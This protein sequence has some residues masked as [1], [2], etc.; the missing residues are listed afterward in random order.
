MQNIF[1]FVALKEWEIKYRRLH[2]PGIVTQDIMKTSSGK[3]YLKN[4]IMHTIKQ[5]I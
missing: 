3:R 2:F 1:L 5:W 4:A